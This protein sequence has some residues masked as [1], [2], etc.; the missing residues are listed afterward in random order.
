MSLYY[1]LQLFTVS[2]KA[3]LR[4]LKGISPVFEVKSGS[5]YVYY[6]GQFTSYSQASQA[7][8]AA[9]R[10]GFPGAIV[11]A[12]YERKSIPVQTARKRESEKR[13][14]PEMIVSYRIFLASDEL[15]ADM[16]REV[17]A[18]T[19]KDI[20]KEIRDSKVEF[21]IGPFSNHTEAANLAQA[22]RDRG[23]TQV[24]VQTVNN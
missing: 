1:R 4:Q 12:Y 5:R 16:I 17:G 24:I 18:L 21:F 19:S 23:F 9:R 15:P 7:L 11:V 3:P 6:A 13:T 8:T 22:L 2:Q 20:V 10:K 14:A